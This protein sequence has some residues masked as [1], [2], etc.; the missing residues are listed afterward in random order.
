MKKI[1][2]FLLPFTLAFAS[3]LY[4]INL[5]SPQRALLYSEKAFSASGN[6]VLPN[7]KFPAT[8]HFKENNKAFL[9]EVNMNSDADKS[10]IYYDWNSNPATGYIQNSISCTRFSL[11]NSSAPSINKLLA[12]VT[13]KNSKAPTKQGVFWQSGNKKKNKN[14]LTF[15]FNETALLFEVNKIKPLSQNL[16]NPANLEGCIDI[17]TAQKNNKKKINKLNPSR[18]VSPDNKP[19]NDFS[20]SNLSYSFYGFYSSVGYAGS[21]FYQNAAEHRRAVNRC[22]KDGEAVCKTEWELGG[23]FGR[24]GY[25]CGDGWDNKPYQPMSSLDYCCQMHD[26]HA[27]GK[28]HLKNLCGFYACVAC[29]E[30]GSYQAFIDEYD[31][32]NI[33]EKFAKTGSFLIGCSFDGW[34]SG[35]SCSN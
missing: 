7:I 26:H 3:N 14:V 8:L 29:S 33:I 4:A 32:A 30:K 5:D 2:H 21:P 17:V 31:A 35:F 23:L 19:Y 1:L 11:G 15:Q 6:V 12:K 10:Y 25:Y 28:N 20:V 34:V 13:S 18:A 9:I 27:W 24:Y 16:F 22:K